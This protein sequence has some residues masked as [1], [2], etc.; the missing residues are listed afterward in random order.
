MKGLGARAVLDIRREWWGRGTSRQLRG[1]G[2]RSRAIGDGQG[3][4]VF[5]G[6]TEFSHES[7][8]PTLGLPTNGTENGAPVTGVA[9]IVVP[10]LGVTSLS[11]RTTNS[12][13]P[14][15]MSLADLYVQDG[16]GWAER[17]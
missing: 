3:P 13:V 12:P 15:P 6:R 1:G 2:F 8:W 9:V 7:R 17:Q 4:D 16:G 14:R 5:D 11:P 10:W